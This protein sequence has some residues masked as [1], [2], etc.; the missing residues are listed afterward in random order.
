MSEK[1]HI[2]QCGH[3]ERGNE[4]SFYDVWGGAM[5]YIRDVESA[6]VYSSSYIQKELFQ[7]PEDRKMCTW[8]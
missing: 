1:S 5:L 3:Q 6:L 2:L 4:I 7:F 8:N